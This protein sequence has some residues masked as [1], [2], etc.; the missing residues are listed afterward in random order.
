MHADA[1]CQV[2]QSKSPSV[3]EGAVVLAALSWTEYAVL[4]AKAVQPAPHLSGGLNITRYLG[5]LGERG[6]TACCG[7]KV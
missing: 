5:A 4:N 6:L 7:F 2:V 1:L 3:K